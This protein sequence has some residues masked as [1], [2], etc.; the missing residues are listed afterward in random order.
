MSCFETTSYTR[1]TLKIV[2][3][4]QRLGYVSR[5]R[6]R[7]REIRK[8]FRPSISEMAIFR[9]LRTPGSR[10]RIEGSLA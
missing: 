1:E 4:P 5:I 9:Q 6:S 3:K 2:I 7:C 10:Q 8:P